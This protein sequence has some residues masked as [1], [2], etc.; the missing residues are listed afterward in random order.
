MNRISALRKRPKAG[1]LPF[2]VLTA[3]VVGAVTLFFVG[4]VLFQSEQGQ[5]IEDAQPGII[6]IEVAEDG[7]YRLAL[8]EIRGTGLDIESLD[9]IDLQLSRDGRPLPFYVDGDNLIFYGEESDSR[10]SRY[11]TYLLELGQS[12][13]EMASV[14]ADGPDTPVTTI[15][16]H[17]HLEENRLY[18]GRARY[19]DAAQNERQGPWYWDTLQVQSQLPLSFELPQL[20]TAEPAEI[21]IEMWGASHDTAVENDHDFDVII[22][23]QTVGR[24]QWDGETHYQ[25]ETTIPA[26]VLRSGQNSLVLDNSFEGATT[27]DI[28]RLDWINLIYPAA[29][30]AQSDRLVIRDTDGTVSAT[31]F[32][33]Q[34]LL[35]DVTDPADPHLLT[36][37]GYEDGTAVIPAQASQRLI[38]VG[39][40]GYL[41]PVSLSGLRSNDLRSTDNQADLLIVTTEQLA[42]SLAPLVEARAEQGIEAAVVPVEAIYDSFGYGRPSPQSITDFLRYAKENWA[43]PTP[44]YLLIVGDASYDYRDYLEGGPK[45]TVPPLMIPVSFSGETV[46]DARLADIDGDFRPDLAVG[47]WPVDSAEAVSSLVRRTLAYEK[48]QAS[49][50]IIFAA[51]GTSPEFSGVSDRI[52]DES[53]LDGETAEKLYGA[54]EAE[55]TDAW[56]QGAWLVNY[57]GHGSLDRWGQQDIFSTEA[58]SGLRSNGSPPIVMQLT[59]LT[60]FFAHPTIS[61]L[62]E[63]MLLNDNGPVLVVAATSLTLSSSQTPFGINLADELENPETERMGDAL[64]NAKLALNVDNLNLR[65]ISDTFGLL[66]DPSALIVRP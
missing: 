21:Q 58:V 50:H 45:N 66:G 17:L 61:S 43:E 42:P 3:I 47:R 25:S 51:D 32:S 4:R 8:N 5:T 46:S 40:D 48:G 9:G 36:G 24:V 34:P 11:G 19:E 2:L 15:P 59:C 1:L 16:Q 23:E 41:K 6:K 35:F 37:W 12:G 18:D 20:N 55:L 22:N 10:Y 28:M 31:G 44:R 52:L 39:P 56:N 33:E 13:P 27:I 30:A 38:A 49:P 65:E 63:Q 54:T 7:L 26:N 14:L 29:P 53:S 62:S 60:G 57:T 64:N